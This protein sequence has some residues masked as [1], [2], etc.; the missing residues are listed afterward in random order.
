MTMPKTICAKERPAKPAGTKSVPTMAYTRPPP[1]GAINAMD[2]FTGPIVFNIIGYKNCVSST[3][4]VPNVARNTKSSSASPIV[5]GTGRVPAVGK[6]WSCARTNVL[7]NRWWTN[8][9]EMRRT[10]MRKRKKKN[11]WNPCLCTLTLKRCYCLTV[12]LRSICRATVIMRKRRFSLWGM[13]GC[14]QFLE[15][16]DELTE[17]EGDD[18]ERPIIVIFHNL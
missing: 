7:F 12:L 15:K 10:R 16:L 18:R 5:A 9:Q 11:R 6:W 17:V 3:K 4:P 1:S 13:N 8:L 14:L 2:A